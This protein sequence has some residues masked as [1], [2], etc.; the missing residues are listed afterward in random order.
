MQKMR[1]QVRLDRKTFPKEFLIE[2]LPRL[3]GH[4]HATATLIRQWATSPSHHLQ[5][6]HDG[7]VNVAV[8]LAF[9]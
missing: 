2:F 4:Q 9:V 7:V 1:R 6:I 3:L 5:N 8:F